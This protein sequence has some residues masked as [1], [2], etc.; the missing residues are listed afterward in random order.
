LTLTSSLL[1]PDTTKKKILTLLHNA[2]SAALKMPQ[3]ETLALWTGKKG[4]AAAVIYHRKP[5]SRRATLTWR[6]TWEFELSR[7]VVDSWQKLAS[8]ACCLLVESEGV[9][10][11]EVNSH[12]DAVHHLGLPGGVVD[13]VS[14]WQIRQEGLM[15]RM[16]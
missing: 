8:D 16:A 4:E 3:L 5:A 1:T 2:S 12:G 9:P 11:N 10:A 13:P 6:G 7:R 15:Q 14:L